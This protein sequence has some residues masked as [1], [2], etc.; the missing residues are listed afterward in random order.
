M[1]T[2]KKIFPM[3]WKFT[4]DVSNFVVGI[5]IYIVLCVPVGIVLGL[6]K[7]IVEWIPLVGNV[8]VWALGVIGVLV[9]LYA[10]IGLVLL[11][12]VYCKVIKD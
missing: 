6:A 5:I 3:S 1:D 8:L 12:L 11:I 2:L 9:G 10:I 7:I 4:A